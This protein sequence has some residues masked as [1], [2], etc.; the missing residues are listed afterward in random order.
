MGKH[1]WRW[2]DQT[3][4]VKC[5]QAAMWHVCSVVLFRCLAYSDPLQTLGLCFSPSPAQILSHSLSFSV[6]AWLLDL[7]SFI[8]LSSVCKLFYF[9]LYMRFNFLSCGFTLSPFQSP[10]HYI[11]ASL[12]LLG[13]DEIWSPTLD[14]PHLISHVRQILKQVNF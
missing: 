7:D 13:D 1:Y 6:S 2:R 3:S 9:Y 4:V 12:A 14:D 10:S 11:L 8:P 5:K